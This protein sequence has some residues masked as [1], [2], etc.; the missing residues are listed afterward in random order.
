MVWVVIVKKGFRPLQKK[1]KKREKKGKE[2]ER[3]GWI[4]ESVV[5]LCDVLVA[6]FQWLPLCL[7]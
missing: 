6:L 4:S 1:K 5:S 3:R 2:E 7:G